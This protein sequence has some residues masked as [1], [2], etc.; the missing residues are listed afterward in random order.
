MYQ[1]GCVYYVYSLR[2]HCSLSVYVRVSFLIEIVTP[3]V[4]SP[5]HVVILVNHE[6]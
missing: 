4:L 5:C 6:C 1:I 2:R 3:S